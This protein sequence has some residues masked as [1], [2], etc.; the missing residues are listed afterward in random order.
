MNQSA[1]SVN[2]SAPSGG[3]KPAVTARDPAPGALSRLNDHAG[4]PEV[5]SDAIE[6]SEHGHAFEGKTL[7]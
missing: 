7:R 2:L 6:V 5:V 1:G 4:M 3:R